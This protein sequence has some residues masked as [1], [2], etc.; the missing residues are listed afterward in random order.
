MDTHL[1]QQSVLFK[2][3]LKEFAQVLVFLCLLGGLVF[4]YFELG[5]GKVTTH[6]CGAETLKRYQGLLG[7]YQS[8]TYFKGGKMQSAAF[9]K[10][11]THSL[12]LTKE[13]AFGFQFEYP[14]LRGNERFTVSV[15]RYSNGKDSRKGILVAAAKS[16][17]K[18]GEE[19]IEKSESGWEKIQFTFE[20]S[21][22]SKNQSLEIYC[23]NQG[24]EPIY[25]DDL[26]ISIERLEPL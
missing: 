26:E 1:D 2:Q 7:F 13:D 16:F 17:W 15:W 24:Y 10:S 22:E 23:W 14:Y 12:K 9:A 5:A 18:A 6:R 19:V 4:F 25:F 8:G 21:K 3:T 11:G 20:P